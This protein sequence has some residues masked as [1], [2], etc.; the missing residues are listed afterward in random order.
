MGNIRWWN[1]NHTFGKISRGKPRIG[2]LK[3]TIAKRP[4]NKLRIRSHY[5]NPIAGDGALIGA[6]L[7]PAGK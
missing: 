5:H 6:K 2:T 7:F 1:F 4:T 3:P